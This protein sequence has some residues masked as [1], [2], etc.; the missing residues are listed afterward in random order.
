MNTLKR[1]NSPLKCQIRRW[2]KPKRRQAYSFLKRQKMTQRVH[3]LHEPGYINSTCAR[4]C[5]TV[6]LQI[7]FCGTPTWA[8]KIR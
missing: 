3:D 5:A 1:K 4:R 2:L 7:F 8:E 6:G